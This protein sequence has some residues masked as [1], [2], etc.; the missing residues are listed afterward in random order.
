MS[1]RFICSSC[2]WYTWIS[3]SSVQTFVGRSAVV[4]RNSSKKAARILFVF[5]SS[6]S[7]VLTNLWVLNM[8]PSSTCISSFKIKLFFFF[9]FFFSHMTLPSLHPSPLSL[10]VSYLMASIEMP[11]LMMKLLLVDPR[12]HQLGSKRVAVGAAFLHQVCPSDPQKIVR[13]QVPSPLVLRLSK[14]E[15]KP[16]LAPNGFTTV[17]ELIGVSKHSCVGLKNKTLVVVFIQAFIALYIVKKLFHHHK[18]LNL[19]RD[20]LTS[21]TMTR[22]TVATVTKW[23]RS[24]RRQ[25]IERRRPRPIEWPR[26]RRRQPW[27]WHSWS[28]SSCPSFTILSQCC[29]YVRS[30]GNISIFFCQ[31]A[32]EKHA[33][34]QSGTHSGSR[35]W[36]WVFSPWLLSP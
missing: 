6:K 26:P 36:Q 8:L 5:T 20:S 24:R 15:K 1:A 27:Q 3:A 29:H 2:S 10:V 13:F 4:W 16:A 33:N 34:C 17:L 7:W 12:V 32:S 14:E 28:P 25:S 30:H 19:A 22:V 11:G 35:W 9:F 31:L 18:I 23:W 21:K